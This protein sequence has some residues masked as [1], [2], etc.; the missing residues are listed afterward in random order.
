M[1]II[2]E[3]ATTVRNDCVVQNGDAHTVEQSCTKTERELFSDAY[4]IATLTATV[5]WSIL[6]VSR[7]SLTKKKSPPQQWTKS[8]SN[9]GSL[10]HNRYICM[11]QFWSTEPL[12][13]C[14]W[15]VSRNKHH[16]K[17]QMK[18]YNMTSLQ[19]TKHHLRRNTGLAG[20]LVQSGQHH[21]LSRR[22]QK[23]WLAAHFS[24]VSE[25]MTWKIALP[26]I[27]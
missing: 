25:Y 23:M 19:Y 1:A 27:E 26:N 14:W 3:L 15:Y 21:K 24:S 17:I 4:C 11:S 22:D 5:Y 16:K 8:V 13:H 6:S 7:I 9:F 10:K 12:T 20:C 2:A 18:Y